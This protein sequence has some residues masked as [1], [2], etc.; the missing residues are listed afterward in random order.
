MTRLWR[1]RNG[2]IALRRPLLM[3][4]VNATPDSFSDGGKFSSVA[5]AIEHGRSLVA[6][7]ADI[8]D[9]GG[10]STRPGADPVSV[11]EELERTIPVVEALADDGFI[12][13]IDTMKP[14]VAEAGLS[15]GA[16]IVNDV[17]GMGDVGMRSVAAER[18]AGV[19]VMHMLGTPRTMQDNP[20]YGDVVTEVGWFL[21]DRSNAA[22][23]AGVSPE[24][25]VVDPGIGFGKTIEHNLALLNRLGEIAQAGFPVMVGSSRK[26]FLGKI[27]GHARPE[28]RDLASGVAVAA[29]IARGAVVLRV[30]NAAIC[31]EA[32]KV[33]W[34]IVR[35][36]AAPWAPVAV[37]GAAER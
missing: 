31:L 12:V 26:A 14:S 29:A 21:A 25:I 18:G 15:A 32:A 24:A 36:E 16:V 35:G 22:I 34:A 33:A 10:E 6:S 11:E 27:T 1:V 20:T 5:A 17:G 4:V 37:E 8:V 9:V 2:V 7:G 13:S 19:V 23:A 3:G 30:H 28:D